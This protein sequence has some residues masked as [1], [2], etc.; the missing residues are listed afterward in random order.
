VLAWFGALVA[1]TS[2]YLSSADFNEGRPS[3]AAGQQ[4]D[5][6]IATLAALTGIAEGFTPLP[7]PLSAQRRG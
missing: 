3:E 4:L 6:L 1:P 2:V 7:P 5:G